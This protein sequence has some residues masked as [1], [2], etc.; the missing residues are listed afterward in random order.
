MITA[1]KGVVLGVGE[2]FVDVM[3]GSGV[4]YRAYVT[5]S[6]ASSLTA[7]PHVEEVLLLTS[8]VVREESIELFGFSTQLE[9]DVFER[10]VAARGIGPKSG[11]A[12][13]DELGV[14][15]VIQAVH[16]EDEKAF[17]RVKGIGRRRAEQLVLELR[18]KFDD[19]EVSEGASGV[20]MH[21]T[22]SALTSLGFP[23]HLAT[24]AIRKAIASMEAEGAALSDN[25]IVAKA[26][27]L[28]SPA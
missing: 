5:S 27:S 2:G 19:L 7:N 4:A 13:I 20:N 3:T 23:K 9:R 21:R 16:T 28:L 15:G 11:L 17:T 12:I 18:G 25:A 10:L 22:V 6:Y 1:I 8:Q 14:D 26:L 24:E